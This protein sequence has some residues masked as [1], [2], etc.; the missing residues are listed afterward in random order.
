MAGPYFF[1]CPFEENIGKIIL[2]TAAEIDLIHIPLVEGQRTEGNFEYPHIIQLFEPN[3]NSV[4]LEDGSF[5]GNT[6]FVVLKLTDG[7][8]NALAGDYQAGR[9]EESKAPHIAFR[10]LLSPPQQISQAKKPMS[11]SVIRLATNLSPV[12]PLVASA[13]ISNK[14][15]SVMIIK[16]IILKPPSHFKE[17]TTVSIL[18]QAHKKVKLDLA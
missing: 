5:Q 6:K 17:T 16:P 13:F 12:F 9:V 18:P 10:H 2:P 14:T 4:V 8:L 1:C 3:D 15:T 7:V 11:A